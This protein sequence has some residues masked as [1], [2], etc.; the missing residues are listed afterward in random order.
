MQGIN[1]AEQGHVVNALPPVDINGG[2]SS[3]IWSMK[4]YGKATII[5]SVGVSAAAFTKIVVNECTAADG[6]GRTAI[7]YSVYKEETAAG[8]TL[9]ER[10]AVAATGVTPSANDNIM[11]VI[12]LDAR[13][14]SADSPWVEVVLTN[15]S[16]NSCLASVL[17][18][19]TGS[20]YGED[21]SP[22]ALA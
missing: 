18:V 22:T 1:H 5:V 20:R 9:G 19:L 8:D 3:D 17:A 16:G 14:L 6:S 15:A 4:N 21:Q 11:Y 13:E 12:D 2:A 7:A 10:T